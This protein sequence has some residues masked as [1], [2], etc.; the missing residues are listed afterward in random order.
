MEPTKIENFLKRTT[1]RQIEVVF[2]LIEHKSMTRAAKALGITVSAVS[3]MSARFEN[4]LGVVLFEP[5]GAKRY[6]LSK[7][8]HEFISR[9]K[10]LLDE[11]NNLRTAL[12]EGQ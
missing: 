9:L 1:L 6:V 3:R 5:P 4:N 10:P 12:A 2:S 11:V 8:G 7:E